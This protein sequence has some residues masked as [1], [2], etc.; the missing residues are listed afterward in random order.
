MV[1]I[2][3]RPR[4]PRASPV[5]QACLRRPG[6]QVLHDHANK[7]PALHPEAAAAIEAFLE[8]GDLRAG[9]TR[10]HCPDCG[11]EY[12]L[13]FTCKVFAP[14]ENLT[15]SSNQTCLRAA[16]RQARRSEISTR[17]LTASE[18]EVCLGSCEPQR[19]FHSAGEIYSLN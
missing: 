1:C 11:H 5:W 9:F 13:A 4:Q 17:C 19:E 18:P 12:L 15:S 3:Y 10:L 7:L 14:R 6:R 16:H 2:R 8:G